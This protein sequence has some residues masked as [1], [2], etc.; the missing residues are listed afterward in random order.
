[1]RE[2][3]THLDLHD[4]RKSGRG[5]IASIA[6]PAVTLH[7]AQCA[8]IDPLHSDPSGMKFFETASE[9]ELWLGQ[10]FRSSWA[11]CNLCCPPRD[12]PRKNAS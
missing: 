8:E 7:C 3:Q 11:S 9:A 6:S 5:F 1:M 12:L 4:L 10:T 2:I